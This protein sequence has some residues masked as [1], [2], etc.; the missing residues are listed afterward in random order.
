[1]IGSMSTRTE[2]FWWLSLTLTFTIA[3]SLSCGCG[4]SRAGLAS[5]SSA[6]PTV[7]AS[8]AE[9][10]EVR[11]AALLQPYLDRG[12][13][14]NWPQAIAAG[15]DAVLALPLVEASPA[16][17]ARLEAVRLELRTAT[18]SR[19]L[20]FTAERKLNAAFEPLVPVYVGDR[21]VIRRAFANAVVK[22]V[23]R[24]GAI[25][26][27]D[28]VALLTLNGDLAS[29]G[30][31]MRE[32]N[33]TIEVVDV[34][35]DGPSWKAGIRPGDTIVLIDGT[36]PRDTGDAAKRLSGLRGTIVDVV[37]RSPDQ[38]SARSVRVHRD[39]LDVSWF[40]SATGS[41]DDL[42]LP[43]NPEVMYVRVRGSFGHGAD[44]S[45]CDA[46]VKTMRSGAQRL[47]IDLRTAPG[48]LLNVSPAL[49]N[50]FAG[51]GPVFAT[52]A[53]RATEVTPPARIDLDDNDLAIPTVVLI[54][55][56]TAGAAE[57]L[58]WSLKHL[59]G[60]TLVGSATFGRGTVQQLFQNNDP[61]DGTSYAKV[62]TSELL[63]GD[64]SRVSGK[65]NPDVEIPV[66]EATAAAIDLRWARYRLNIDR[67]TPPVEFDPVL[68]RAV[69]ALNLE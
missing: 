4:G 28:E 41:T 68:K 40:V 9:P 30:T 61:D 43:G 16:A 54:G 27:S 26:W 49:A 19:D 69:T 37:V 42:R 8:D 57:L 56:G 36:A 12:P 51:T 55:S 21:H 67:S 17:R 31:R 32:L 50:L 22:E 64:G 66:D 3:A 20:L 5:S 63:F 11:F 13:P 44:E 15:V 23:D 47:V 35:A 58:A 52:R 25:L 1:M 60:A 7:I 46:I 38:P 33:G 29:T 48:G 39:A 24:D 65:L 18:V 59:S 53:L 6:A 14:A 10:S 62:T 34:E 45:L 2:R